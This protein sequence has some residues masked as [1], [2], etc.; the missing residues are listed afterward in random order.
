MCWRRDILV[1][2]S[3][4]VSLCAVVSSFAEVW[5]CTRV[6][7]LHAFIHVPPASTFACSAPPPLLP[8]MPDHKYLLI[9]LQ[10]FSSLLP[11]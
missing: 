6:S 10:L 7:G 4:A 3:R 1:H 11:F 5:G 9:Y 8:G 2:A